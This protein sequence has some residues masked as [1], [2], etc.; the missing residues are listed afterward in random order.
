MRH[1]PALPRRSAFTLIELLVVIAI[2]A[3]L[4]ALLL[5]AVQ[6]A[7]EAARRSSCKNN[8]KQLGLALHNYH[9]THSMFPINWTVNHNFNEGTQEGFSW[10][11][12]V[13]P[14]MEQ[15]PLYDTINFDVDLADAGN[16][17]AAQTAI[18]T[19]L[20]P[21]DPLKQNGLLPNRANAPSAGT[22]Y[23]VNNY[24]AV[25][26]SNWNW[27]D[28][29]G[30]VCVTCRRNPNQPNGLDGPNGLI[31]RRTGYHSASPVTLM[32][33][34][35][36]GTSN[37]LAIGEALPGGSNH[38]WWWNPNATTATAGVPLNYYYPPNKYGIGD[39]PRNYSFASEHKGGAQFTLVD[40]SVRFVG[41]NIDNDLYRSLATISGGESIGEF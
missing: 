22:S 9:D 15:G 8:L 31:G 39:W 5:P 16:N 14:F 20:C 34:V 37:T 26:G 36:D 30:V 17:A 21:S 13:L 23:G 25:A 40:G 10:M 32:K 24:K 27:G 28:H 7:R 33:D 41:E 35:T 11:A 29:T 18:A 38:T 12:Y 1:G 2:I 3:I 4:V 19:Y 6:Q